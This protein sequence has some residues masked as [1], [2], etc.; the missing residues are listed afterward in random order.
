MSFESDEKLYGA[1]LN[2]STTFH[3]IEQD[4]WLNAFNMSN[5]NVLREAEF[6]WPPFNMIK[7]SCVQKLL[8][9]IESVFF[10]LNINTELNNEE[11]RFQNAMSFDPFNTFKNFLGHFLLETS[12]KYIP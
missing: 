9:G 5:L 1:T 12:M 3:I 4:A 8:N 2:N 11:F 7:Q 6:V 10:G